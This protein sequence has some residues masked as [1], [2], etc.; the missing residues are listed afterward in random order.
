MR[1]YHF[2]LGPLVALVA[3][4]V[5]TLLSRWAFGAPHRAEP[6]H[7][8][9]GRPDYGLLV[10][11]ATA[12]RRDEAETMRRLLDEAGI[13][14]TVA[15]DRQTPDRQPRFHVLVFPDAAA[16]AREVLAGSDR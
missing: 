9:T 13:R 10:P 7:G 6:R 5:L 12:G 11:V 8:S 15:P 1:S 4:G 16:R 14:G 3:V 2:M